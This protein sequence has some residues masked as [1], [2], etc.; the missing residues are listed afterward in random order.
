MHSPILA[1]LGVVK[2]IFRYIKGTFTYV[3]FLHVNSS[4]ELTGYSDA[5]S[6]G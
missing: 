5:D 4:L 6:A 3:L 1:H 2:R